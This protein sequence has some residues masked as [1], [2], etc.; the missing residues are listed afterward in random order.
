M[1]AIRVLDGKEEFLVHC[2]GFIVKGAPKRK[3]HGRIRN[4]S[5]F[6]ILIFLFLEDEESF[7]GEG[8]VNKLKNGHGPDSVRIDYL[9]LKLIQS[10]ISMGHIFGRSVS[11]VV[12]WFP[13]HFISSAVVPHFFLF[14]LSVSIVTLKFCY[15]RMEANINICTLLNIGMND[16]TSI[17]ATFYFSTISI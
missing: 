11:S 9:L 15:N 17:F 2:Q 8:N 5:S 13:A 10:T 14:S 4:Y 6:I 12:P 1:L 16:K 7:R 3:L